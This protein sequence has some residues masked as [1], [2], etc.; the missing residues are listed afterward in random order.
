MMAAVVQLTV[1]AL[2]LQDSSSQHAWGWLAA[3]GRLGCSSSSS[4][5]EWVFLP[6]RCCCLAMCG[7]RKSARWSTATLEVGW[8]SHCRGRGVLW[9]VVGE[10]ISCGC[11]GVSTLTPLGCP[12]EAGLGSRATACT[13]SFWAGQAAW[14][15][16]YYVCCCC[17]CCYYRFRCYYHFCCQVDWGPNQS[18]LFFRFSR[19]LL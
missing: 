19:A 17:C 2:Q 3:G 12:R 16:V 8:H 11:T 10:F 9:L 13:A 6:G 14:H 7:G 15:H 18:P 1:V 4:K 5:P